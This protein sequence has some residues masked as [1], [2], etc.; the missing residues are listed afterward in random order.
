MQGGARVLE[1]LQL[2]M[3]Q[4]LL[5]HRDGLSMDSLKRDDIELAKSTLGCQLIGSESYWT[6]WVDLASD[7]KMC[8]VELIFGPEIDQKY[9]HC[10]PSIQLFEL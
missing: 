4:F 8:L 3:S 1:F 6:N 7:L 5:K 9:S 2:P 10:S